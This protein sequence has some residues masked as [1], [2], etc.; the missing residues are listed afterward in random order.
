MPS[1]KFRFKNLRFK[2]QSIQVVIFSVLVIA[3]HLVLHFNDKAFIELPDFIVKHLRSL[4]VLITT[5]FIISLFLRLSIKRVFNFFDEPEEKIFYSKI[6][7]WLLYTIGIFIVLHQLGV[8]LGNITLFIGLI[9]TGLAFA[10]RDVLMSFF[11]WMIL[12]RKKPFRIG[13]YIRIGEDE[14]KVIHIGTFYVLLDNTPEMAED[15]IRVPNRLFLEK[16]IINLGKTH[17]HESLKLQITSIPERKL[18]EDAR[19]GIS[20]LLD[21]NSH[22]KVYLSL[23]GDKPGLRIAYFV[24]YEQKDSIKN[25]VIFLLNE[26]FQG[27]LFFLK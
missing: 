4:S 22:V 2:S 20:A 12:L 13:D 16:S 17:Y 8:S 1:F 23:E 25:E 10:V 5:F 7:S 18:M 24:P 21:A 6:Y 11:G 9:A 19:I 15:Y 3:I 26:V 14:G 27:I